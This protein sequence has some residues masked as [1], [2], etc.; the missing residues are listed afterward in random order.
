[1]DN[2][3]VDYSFLPFILW[4]FNEINMENS[5]KSKL[6]LILAKGENQV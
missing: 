6:R 5:V 4:A 3:L 1:M 2:D